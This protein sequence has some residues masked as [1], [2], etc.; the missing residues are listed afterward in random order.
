M[1]LTKINLQFMILNAQKITLKTN[2][3]I[4]KAEV[5]C[6]D[7]AIFETNV[8]EIDVKVVKQSLKFTNCKLN[9]DDSEKLSEK[10]NKEKEGNLKKQKSRKLKVKDSEKIKEAEEEDYDNIKIASLI[11][12]NK[13]K[14]KVHVHGG[15]LLTGNLSPK[16]LNFIIPADIRTQYSVFNYMIIKIFTQ[17]Q[18]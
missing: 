2:L 6:K 5:E 16:F 7:E 18:F 15:K 12:K 3:K 10:I 8:Y 17:P 13:R 14:A 1:F 9:K 4:Q 11:N